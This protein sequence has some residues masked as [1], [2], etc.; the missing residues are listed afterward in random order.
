MVIDLW[1]VGEDEEIDYLAVLAE[2]GE[3]WKVYISK[4]EDFEYSYEQPKCN[5]FFS[6]I[7]K[8]TCQ[9]IHSLD[10]PDLRIVMAKNKKHVLQHLNTN[11]RLIIQKD[12]IKKYPSLPFQSSE[13]YLHLGNVLFRSFL[14][15]FRLTSFFR[16]SFL[17]SINNLLQVVFSHSSSFLEYF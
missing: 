12:F 8:Y 10:I 7:G 3:F 13:K 16:E 15:C 11:L 9:K 4:F 1:K 14:T 6:M 2:A 5:V 17:A